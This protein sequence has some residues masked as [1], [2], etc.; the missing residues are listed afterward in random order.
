MAD[1]EGHE[2]PEFASL[3]GSRKRSRDERKWKKTV[4]KEKRNSVCKT[5][6]A[7][8]HGISRARVDRALA[9]VTATGV[10]IPDQ[11]GKTGLHGK[12]SEERTVK[13]L[14][15]IQGKV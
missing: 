11:R 5:A 9:S 4:A 13:S 2:R 6:F 3:S 8:I 1:G 10:L 15:H 14:E 7:N 12:I